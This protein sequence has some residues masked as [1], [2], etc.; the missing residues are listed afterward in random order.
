MDASSKEDKE[1]ESEFKDIAKSNP[2]RIRPENIS[3]HMGWFGA[4]TLLNRMNKSN[5]TWGDKPY[6]CKLSSVYYKESGSESG[7]THP[8]NTL[9]WT[10]SETFSFLT[11][12]YENTLDFS[13]YVTPFSVAT[14]FGILLSAVIMNIA[15]VAFETLK[16]VRTGLQFAF[17]RF[18]LSAALNSSYTPPTW[19][20]KRLCYRIIMVCWFGATL[21]LNNLYTSKAI[22]GVTSPLAKRTI[23][24]F[25]ELTKFRFCEDCTPM[26]FATLISQ[27]NLPI[28]E[29]HFHV[30][31][32]P[33]DEIGNNKQPQQT[34]KFG[35]ALKG[36][37]K[38]YSWKE[39][40]K[41]LNLTS[42]KV[43]SFE[44]AMGLFLR[45]DDK[46]FLPA[47]VGSNVLLSALS[48]IE[49]EVTQCEK[50]NVFVDPTEYVTAEYRYL[51][52]Q[53]H[54]INFT[55]S[56]EKV[57][58]SQNF[59]VIFQ[60][61]GAG[62]QRDYRR[63][64]ESGILDHM[65]KY[66]RSILYLSRRKNTNRIKNDMPAKDQEK[67]KPSGMSSGFQTIFII[68][69]GA[70]LVSILVFLMEVGYET[71]EQ[72]LIEFA[73]SMVARLQNFLVYIVWQSFNRMIA[74]VAFTVLMWIDEFVRFI[75]Y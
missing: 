72:K 43:T 56:E 28:N 51:S 54:W 69:A 5:K 30:Y 35:E 50:R 25:E 18:T 24:S 62:M 31:S 49:K 29:D 63:L 26:E 64:Q 58:W 60:D 66:Y 7:L 40:D 19:M 34:S 44:R 13:F 53:Y 4:Y 3:Q 37:Y 22:T 1:F 55:L 68:Y 10:G 27:A 65:N 6:A 67:F 41:K 45:K 70:M 73:W 52:D 2:F 48:N 75:G 11:C 42:V 33:V 36:I 17:C 57:L 74:F 16:N 20:T 15:F 23:R 71:L 14:W 46:A 39:K 59:M 21:L 38:V 12:H 9:I 8:G 47:K 32:T 61:Y